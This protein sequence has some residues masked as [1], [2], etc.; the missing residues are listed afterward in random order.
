MIGA[1]QFPE[2]PNNRRQPLS[3]TSVTPGLS[4]WAEICSNRSS[5][6][7]ISFSANVWQSEKS[8]VNNPR[9][10]RHARRLNLLEFRKPASKR[11]NPL[12]PHPLPARDSTLSESSRLFSPSHVLHATS[13]FPGT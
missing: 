4:S 9:Q 1:L 3:A 5:R 12:Y 6:E 10:Q 11:L 8:L 2:R 7:L 13:T